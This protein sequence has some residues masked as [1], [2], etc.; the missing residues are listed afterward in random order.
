[1][2][3]E[4]AMNPRSICAA[5]N[6]LIRACVDDSSAQ[7]DAA[8]V[9]REAANRDALLSNASDRDRFVRELRRVVEQH[10][11]TARSDGSLMRRLH[12]HARHAHAVL[13][14]SNEGDAYQDCARLET[15][16][17][18]LYEATL[19]LRLPNDVRSVVEHQHET[20]ARDEADLRRKSF[21]R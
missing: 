14:G 9:V 11:G 20:I 10:G 13:V 18:D 1:M 21:L 19:E 4:T 16:T 3:P 8:G 5:M 15:Q 17:A 2:P 7:T 6:R 12:L